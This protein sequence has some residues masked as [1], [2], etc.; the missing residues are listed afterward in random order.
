MTIQL[1]CIL[2]DHDFKHILAPSF[3][4]DM[5]SDDTVFG[6]KLK[7]KALMETH[8]PNIFPST[9]VVW[10]CPNLPDDGDDEILAERIQGLDFSNVEETEM[11][12]GK[13]KVSS[14]NMPEEG[15]LLLQ[16]PSTYPHSILLYSNDLPLP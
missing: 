4:I 14:L 13:L 11:L 5:P 12:P 3:A 8:F 7:V 1:W 16:M 10:K 6:L 15:M 2:V 9:L